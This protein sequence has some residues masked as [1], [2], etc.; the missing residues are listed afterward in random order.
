MEVHRPGQLLER[1]AA[2]VVALDQAEDRH[3]A[4]QV[5]LR[6]QRCAGAGRRRRAHEG[7]QQGRGV[8]PGG[9]DAA[10]AGELQLGHDLPGEAEQLGH[11]RGRRA[12]VQRQAE[13]SGRSS[14]P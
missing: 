13:A 8:A 10:G 5:P 4:G 1:Q 6:A 9:Q 11:D 7:R 12:V 3:Q 2:G 14:T